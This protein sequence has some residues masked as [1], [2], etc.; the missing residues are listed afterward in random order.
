MAASAENR[1]SVKASRRMPNAK[2][3]ARKIKAAKKI[4]HQA[5]YRQQW[6]SWL[7]SAS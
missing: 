4:W 3:S 5:A 2:L 7:I 6:R 1:L